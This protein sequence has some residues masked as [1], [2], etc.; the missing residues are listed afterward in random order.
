MIVRSLV[1][2]N[3]VT[4]VVCNREVTSV[5]HLKLLRVIALNRLPIDVN[6]IRQRCL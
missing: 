4:G 5:Q 3:F 1:L 2:K 6:L